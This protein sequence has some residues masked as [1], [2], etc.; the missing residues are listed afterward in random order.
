MPGVRIGNHVVVGAGSVVTKYVP[1]HYVA[2]GNPAKVQ[3][4]GIE[5]SNL[6]QIV[7]YGKRVDCE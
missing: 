3:K 2:V 6:G 5:I 1:D 4:T 7:N